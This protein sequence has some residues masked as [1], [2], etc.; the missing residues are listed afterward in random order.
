MPPK[1]TKKKPPAEEAPLTPAYN[2]DAK[3]KLWLGVALFMAVIIILWGWAFKL[4]ISSI[5]WKNS[6]EN[7]LPGQV[8][9]SWDEVF[10]DVK[11]EETKDTVKKQIQNLID[12]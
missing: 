4:N 6:A 9:K 2:E 8:K 7:G 1:K 5:S 3:T 11:A 10:S 12:K